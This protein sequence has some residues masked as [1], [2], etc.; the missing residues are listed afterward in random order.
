MGEHL[1]WK[2]EV[3]R[4]VW[5]LDLTWKDNIKIAWK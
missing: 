1:V 5:R 4:E 2:V 3:Y